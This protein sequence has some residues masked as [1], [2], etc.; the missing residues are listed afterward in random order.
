[1]CHCMANARDYFRAV[2]AST[3]DIVGCRVV[4]GVW[5]RGGL[6]SLEACFEGGLAKGPLGRAT[7]PMSFQQNTISS[8]ESQEQLEQ[9]FTSM[10][11]QTSS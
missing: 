7:Q 8:L 9:H 2:R 10:L 11:R 6:A 1:M 5:G 4:N 3:V